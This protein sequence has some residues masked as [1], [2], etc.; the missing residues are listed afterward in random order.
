MRR[1]SPI[2]IALAVALIGSLA[3]VAIPAFY[4][5][6]ELSQF[7]EATGGLTRLATQASA[8]ANEHEHFPSSA[9]LTP[10]DVPRGVKAVDPPGTWESVETWKALG[11][12]PAAEGSAHAYS[13]AFDSTDQRRSF[14]A[15]SR[16]DLDGDGTLSLFEVGGTWVSSPSPHVE[17]K[18]GIYIESEFE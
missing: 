17:M 3:A 8:F 10:H 7:T 12:R 16:G 2:E 14:T 4:R 1:A 5:N 6:L 11:F 13:F 9:P 18:P 15:Q